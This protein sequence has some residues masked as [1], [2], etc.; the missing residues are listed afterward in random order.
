MLLSLGALSAGGC[1]SKENTVNAGSPMC[2]AGEL[3]CKSTAVEVCKEDGSGFELQ[4]VCSGDTAFCA[5]GA[6]VACEMGSQ[7][8]SGNILYGRCQHSSETE[9]VVQDCSVVNQVC[10]DGRC[11]IASCEPASVTCE[12]N[13]VVTCSVDGLTIAKREPCGASQQCFDGK[14]EKWVCRP[15]SHCKNTSQVE[16]CSEDGLTMLEMRN[17]SAAQ[18]CEEGECRARICTPGETYCKDGARI[19]CSVSGTAEEEWPCG[20]RRS[21]ANNDQCEDWA[22]EPNTDFC[23]EAQPSRCAADGLSATALAACSGDA[24]CRA[25]ACESWVCPAGED[26]CQGNQP[27]RCA[28]DGLSSALL[29]PACSGSLPYCEFAAC[30]GVPFADY[31]G[32]ARWPLPGTPGHPFSYTLN[33][34]E[35]VVDNVTGLEWQRAA[36][37]GAQTWDAA[38]G[39]CASLSWGGRSDWRLPTRMELFSLVDYARS[40]PAVDTTAFPATANNRFWAATGRTGGAERWYVDFSIGVAYVQSGSATNHVRCVAAATP[41]Q[42]V[43]S[44]GHFFEVTGNTVLDTATGLEWQGGAS[45]SQQNQINSIMYCTQLT[46]DGKTD[47]RLP[48]VAELSSLMPGRKAAAPY[49]DLTI[50]PGTQANY[51]SATPVSGSS[52]YWYVNFGTGSTHSLGPSVPG[53]ARCVR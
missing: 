21:C 42:S 10:S 47:W 33:A 32:Y 43:P 50:F 9:V 17:C 36:F 16:V 29:G 41:Q 6:C 7:Y 20:A 4:E 19:V 27:S 5:G 1:G 53:L 46:L 31:D 24:S 30:E 15:G 26:Y 8:C 12:G 40:T 49:I 3:R 25:G 37:P 38:E 23:D 52:D 45:P 44:S 2:Q 18:A 28:A 51:W 14:C 35:T 48:T 11:R 22:C 13:T 39:Y 34:A